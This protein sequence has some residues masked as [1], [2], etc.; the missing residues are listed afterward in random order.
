MKKYE[1]WNSPSISCEQSAPIHVVEANSFFVKDNAYHFV[2]TANNNLHIILA[3]PGMLV[4]TRSNGVR[5]ETG[6]PASK[7]DVPTPVVMRSP[8]KVSVF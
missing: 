4:R 3:T 2:D 5:S 1:I 6:Q 8:L 7:S